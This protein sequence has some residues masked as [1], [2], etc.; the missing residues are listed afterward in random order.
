MIIKITAREFGKM[1]LAQKKKVLGDALGCKVNSI[2]SGSLVNGCFGEYYVRHS[3]DGY[4]RVRVNIGL[5]GKA[6]TDK[7]AGMYLLFR[8]F[9][10]SKWVENF[11][12]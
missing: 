4:S 10:N 9:V 11:E 8:D 7:D 2:V 5:D 6:M 3:D 12:S 1:T